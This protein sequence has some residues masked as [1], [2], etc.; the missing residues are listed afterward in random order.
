MNLFVR[1]SLLKGILAH[2]DSCASILAVDLQRTKNVDV[3]MYS[4]HISLFF[5]SKL[6]G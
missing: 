5:V 2:H 1:L 4:H 6:G 3:K